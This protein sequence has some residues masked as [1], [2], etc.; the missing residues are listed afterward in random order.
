MEIT[1]KADL[2]R[3]HPGL[4]PFIRREPLTRAHKVT[5]AAKRDA[6]VALIGRLDFQNPRPG[7]LVLGEDVIDMVGEVAR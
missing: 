7:V 1:T 3:H 5:F 4:G 2:V 6:L